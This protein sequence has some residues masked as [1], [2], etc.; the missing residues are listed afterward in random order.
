[1]HYLGICVCS[2]TPKD[3]LEKIDTE[4]KMIT[5][6]ER[7]QTKQRRKASLGVHG[8]FYFLH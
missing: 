5:S 4:L 1:M 3:R 6:T 8:V 2:R 7:E